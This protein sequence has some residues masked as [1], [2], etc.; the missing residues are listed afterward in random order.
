MKVCIYNTHE[1]AP[2]EELYE[3]I[4]YKKIFFSNKE[5]EIE[6]FNNS[7]G[8]LI[9]SLL[10]EDINNEDDS[11][12]FIPLDMKNTF[13][14]L[15]NKLF[16][17]TNWVEKDKTDKPSTEQLG[18]IEEDDFSIFYDKVEIT[19]TIE[20]E[21]MKEEQ[22]QLIELFDRIAQHDNGIDAVLV[23][24][25]DEILFSSTP[26][27]GSEYV[28]TDSFVVQID[29]FIEML[30]MTDKVNQELQQFNSAQLLFSGGVV[31]ITHLPQ[32]HEY[33]FL[34]FVGTDADELNL[35]NF[36]RKK[37]LDEIYALLDHLLT[38]A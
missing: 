26:K 7:N 21:T 9:T 18:L 6:G 37:H 19:S 29:H 20:T 34:V 1:E 24:N 27:E 10:P 25:H 5:I 36:Y 13:I 4:G 14:K 3:R 11:L 16:H 2:F 12:F 35:L 15:V 33:T 22:K 23:C 31:H 28:D 8:E 32:Y 17:K 38:G 30:K